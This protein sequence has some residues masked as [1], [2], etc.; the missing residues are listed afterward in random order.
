ML[1]GGRS[2]TGGITFFPFK[3]DLDRT[4]ADN[5]RGMT[6][7]EYELLKILAET[8]RSEAVMRAQ[9]EYQSSIE[10]IEHVWKLSAELPPESLESR[11]EPRRHG[12]FMELV[13]R[14]TEAMPG[15]FTIHQIAN[16]LMIH[17]IALGPDLSTNAVSM[18]LK[19]LHGQGELEVLEL[20]A[21]K[22]AT[23]YRRHALANR[24]RM[25]VG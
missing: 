5:P 19:R 1:D 9:H 4:V 17:E 3:I 21:G 15:P 23:T 25:V 11:A 2:R 18:A 10:S 6:H 16:H 20:G 22:R 7:R 12:E 8:K 24:P 13:R 14:A